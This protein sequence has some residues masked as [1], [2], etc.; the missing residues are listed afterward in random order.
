MPLDRAAPMRRGTVALMLVAAAAANGQVPADEVRNWFDD[1]FL[2]LTAEVADC[3]TPAGPFVTRQEN[4]AS[5]H[6]RA[7]K[8][9]TAWLAGEADRP[10]A[11]AYDQ[12]IAQAL[13]AAFRDKNRFPGSSLWATVQGRVVFVE[14]CMRSEAEVPEVEALVRSLPHV[15]QAVAIVRTQPGAPVP[16]RVMPP[17]RTGPGGK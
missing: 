3:P 16:Y 9:T 8:G 5:S 13:A 1:P 11:F 2:R 10:K 4:L 7:E 14:G 6:H 15:Q 17:Q 12:D